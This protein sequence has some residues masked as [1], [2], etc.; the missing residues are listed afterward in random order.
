[1]YTPPLVAAATYGFGDVMRVLLDAGAHADAADSDGDNALHAAAAKPFHRAIACLLD[2]ESPCATAAPRAARRSLATAQ[3]NRLGKSPLVAVLCAANYGR[4]QRAAAEMLAPHS[5]LSDADFRV[6]A[7]HIRLQ[8]L[9]TMASGLADLERGRE[10]NGDGLCW[11]PGLHWSFPASDRAVI[12]TTY[13]LAR[14]GGGALPPELWLLVFRNVRRGWFVP[15]VQKGPL[16]PLPAAGQCP[17]VVS[18]TVREFAS[19]ACQHE[20]RTL[21]GP[22]PE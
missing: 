1:M 18:A 16:P 3:R 21:R 11:T 17:P 9:V 7:R 5:S 14:R 4:K 15:E 13:E 20:L 6:L 12:R 22:P 19:E 2:Y 10:V 8:R